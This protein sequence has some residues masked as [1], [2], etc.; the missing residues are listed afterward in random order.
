MPVPSLTS[1]EMT[2]RLVAGGHFIVAPRDMD[3]F[4][5]NNSACPVC[6]Q[7]PL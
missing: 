6:G 1:E 2:E 4:K 5:Y 7:V 3:L